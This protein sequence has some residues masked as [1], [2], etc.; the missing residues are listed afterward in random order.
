MD[1]IFPNDRRAYTILVFADSH[2][3]PFG[4]SA[5]IARSR[6]EFMTFPLQAWAF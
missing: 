2:L 1:S 6:E 4:S 3:S 5:E